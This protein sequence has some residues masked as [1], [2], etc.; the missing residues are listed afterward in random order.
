[1]SGATIAL[2]VVSGLGTLFG[3]WGIPAL[4]LGIIAA[5]RKDEP[6]T[7]ASLTRWGWIALVVCFVLAIL[8]FVLL[9]ALLT[10]FSTNN[11]FSSGA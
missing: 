6:S 7:S 2:L 4:I 5:A 10:S 1:M 8:A 11:N 9:G 3:G